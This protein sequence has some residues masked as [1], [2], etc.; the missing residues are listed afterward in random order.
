[1]LRAKA[2]KCVSQL[3]YARAGII[4]PEMEYIAIRENQGLELLKDQFGE[5]NNRSELMPE[6]GAVTDGFRRLLQLRMSFIPYLY[7][8][9]NQYR[10]TGKPSKN[11]RRLEQAANIMD[12][13]AD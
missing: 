11:R 9:F 8:A 1:M 13:A 2:G 7:T 10:S 12:T 3:T 5:K 6:R 4:T